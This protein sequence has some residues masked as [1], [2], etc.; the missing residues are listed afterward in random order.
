MKG[1][2]IQT[3]LPTMQPIA[4]IYGVTLSQIF[5]EVYSQT[6][7]IVKKNFSALNPGG[8]GENLQLRICKACPLLYAKI[9]HRVVHMKVCRMANGRN[10]SRAVPYNLDSVFFAEIRKTPCGSNTADKTHMNPYVID[11]AP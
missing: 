10:V 9:G 4:V 2:V 8:A 7:Q 6:R 5:P 3:N 11:K 1:P